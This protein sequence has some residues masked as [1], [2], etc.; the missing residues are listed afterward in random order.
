MR[1]L[2]VLL[3]L[4]M[5]LP[6]KA[7]T[8]RIAT[9][10]IEHLWAAENQGKNPRTPM[11]Y[12]KLADYALKL[13]ADVIA[14]Q[15]IENEQAIAKIFDPEQYRFHVSSRQIDGRFRQRTAFAVRRSI[16]VIRNPDLDELGTSPGLRYGVDIE[17]SVAGQSIRLLSVHLKS[18]CF[19]EKLSP[20]SSLGKHCRSLASQLAVLEAWI[21]GNE[22]ENRP[23]IVLGDFNRR[24]NLENDDFWLEIDD[25]YP[26]SLQLFRATDGS[27]STCWN[28]KY[29]D[30]ID[31]IVYNRPVADW[32]IPGSF[33]QIVYSE[34]SD[35]VKTLSD[36]CPISVALNIR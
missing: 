15:E 2:L 24:L 14:L 7:D 4:C 18:F 16:P 17:I 3:L 12:E 34:P 22:L 11:D 35:A 13:D 33:Q 31:H 30:Y 9:W 32:V 19:E 5:S 27:W 1:C 23:F 25:G 10:N 36:H 20:E 21:D 8:V 28:S 6:I 29:P 26:V